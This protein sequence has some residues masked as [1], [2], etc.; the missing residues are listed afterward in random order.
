M[1][2]RRAGLAV[3]GPPLGEDPKSFL[4]A[5][6]QAYDK[7][8]R[9]K[10]E[11]HDGHPDQ[12]LAEG[13]AVHIAAGL[14]TAASRTCAAHGDARVPPFAFRAARIARMRLLAKPMMAFARAAGMVHSFWAQHMTVRRSTPRSLA[15]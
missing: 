7:R 6:Q 4:T 14:P 9:D 2:K 3:A 1:L 5:E 12:R 10:S 11:D 13:V 15:K 8:Q